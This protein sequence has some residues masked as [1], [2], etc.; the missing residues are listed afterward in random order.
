M[1]GVPE[2]WLTGL[3]LM[4]RMAAPAGITPAD[5]E[6][7]VAGATRLLVEWGAQL[8]LLGWT[9]LDLFAV[10]R[11]RPMNRNDQAGLVRFLGQDDVRAVTAT[12]ATLRTWSGATQTFH[13][14]TPMNTDWVLMWELGN[15]S[16]QA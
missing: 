7:L 2:A 8:A 15:G 1:P 11:F 14:R 9:T 6:G 10:H 16:L 4:S 13:R 3:A 12:T 5:W